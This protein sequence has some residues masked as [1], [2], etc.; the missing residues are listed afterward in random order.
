MTSFLGG[1]P[2]RRPRSRGTTAPSGK[3]FCQDKLETSGSPQWWFR[4][5]SL[6]RFGTD[7]ECDR[8]TDRQTPRRWQR[9]AKHAAFA[10]K[11]YSYSPLKLAALQNVIF[12]TKVWYLW[13]L[14]IYLISAKIIYFSAYCDFY[15]DRSGYRQLGRKTDCQTDKPV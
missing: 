6:R 7:Y 13:S 1:T 10:R 8:Q 3:K 14:H 15:N 4:D 12:S 2:L 5:P 11:N 9:R